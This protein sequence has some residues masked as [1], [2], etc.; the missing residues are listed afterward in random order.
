MAMARRL[1]AMAACLAFQ[2]FLLLAA[3]ALLRAIMISLRRLWI[4][5]LRWRII[6]NL[7]ALAARALRMAIILAWLTRFL[8]TTLRRTTFFLAF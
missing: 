1:A 6:R 7:A 5:I 4:I 8:M 2:L 3:A